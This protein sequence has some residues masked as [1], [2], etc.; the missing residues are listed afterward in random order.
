MEYGAIDLHKRRSQIRIVTETG[1]VVLERRIDTT[2]AALTEVFGGRA[3]LR[4][5]VESSTESEWVAQALEALGHEVV[6]ADPSFGAMYATRS[7]RVKTDGR[8][9]AALAEACRT[10]MYRRA[11][12]ASAAARGLR[13]TLRVR[14]QLVRQRASTI[15]L[16]RALLRQEGLRLGSGTAS[17]VVDRL[18]QVAVPAALATGLAPLRD[19]LTHLTTTLDAIDEALH[20]RAAQDVVTQQ[21][22]SAPGVGPVVALTFQAVLDTPTR[23]RDAGAVTAYLG[24]VPSEDSSGERRRKGSITKAGP[25][26]LRALLV[27]ASWVIWRGKRDPGV[28]LRAWAHALAGRRG[29]RIAVVALARRLARVLFALWRDGT[30]FR[31]QPTGA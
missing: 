17:R 16:L 6:V 4:V 23:F 8:D 29:R 19:L 24:L 15:C 31:V 28:G 26:D 13:R 3:Q 25:R 1:A 27:Q 9:V 10:G 21:L 14:T 12:R 30:D 22:M 7:K 11:H 18:A 5:L 2:R 20:A